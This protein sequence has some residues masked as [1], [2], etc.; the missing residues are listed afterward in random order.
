MVATEETKTSPSPGQSKEEGENEATFGNFAHYVHTNEGNID[1]V[2]I[3][4]HSFDSEWILDSGASKHVTGNIREFDSYCP[5]PPTHRGTLFPYTTL[6]RSIGQSWTPNLLEMQEHVV[7]MIV[8]CWV[9]TEPS[10][11]RSEEHTSE[12]QS[13]RRISYAVFCLKK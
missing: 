2:S 11:P 12:L 7:L 1:R 6:F 9:Y 10:P 13:L 5:Y 8:L 3:A 4:T